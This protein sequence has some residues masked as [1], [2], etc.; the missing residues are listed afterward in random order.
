MSEP[1]DVREETQLA[2]LEAWLRNEAEAR[3]KNAASREDSARNM[4]NATAEELRAGKATAEKM[5]GRKLPFASSTVEAARASARMDESI[6]AKLRNEARQLAAW[7]EALP[8]LLARVKEL[9]AELLRHAKLA[10]EGLRDLTDLKRL[11]EQERDDFAR[12]CVERGY[13]DTINDGD[14]MTA[15][16]VVAAVRAEQAEKLPREG[17]EDPDDPPNKAR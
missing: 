12:R 14:K 10:E 3:T 7:A 4:R 1:F 9:D 17:K 15:A 16:Q 5:A 13:R 6:A 2:A 11:T 8:A